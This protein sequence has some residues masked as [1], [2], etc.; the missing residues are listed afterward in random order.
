M[1]WNNAAT[2][3]YFTDLLIWRFV[4]AS[5]NHSGYWENSCLIQNV[6]GGQIKINIFMS[7]LLHNLCQIY[8]MNWGYTMNIKI[9]VAHSP[10][11]SWFLEMA[12]RKKF[13]TGIP[14]NGLNA[15]VFIIFLYWHYYVGRTFS[16]TFFNEDLAVARYKKVK[17]I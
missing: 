5:E 8:G 7:S 4:E 2:A 16:I 17:M 10:E 13:R 11:A 1:Q 3:S 14:I 9:T 15:S 6:A 12:S